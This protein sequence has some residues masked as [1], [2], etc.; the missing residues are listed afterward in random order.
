LIPPC[1]ISAALRPAYSNQYPVTNLTDIY[2]NCVLCPRHCRVDR[3]DR[4]E[5]AARGICG[6]SDRLRVAY[7]GPHFGEEPP[8]TGTNGSGTIFFSG[9]S[10]RCTYCQNHQI[11]HE[12]LGMAMGLDA[13][14]ERVTEVARRDRVHNIN[15]VTPDHFFPHVFALVSLLRTQG[16]DLPMVYNLSGYQ[17]AQSLVRAEAYADIYLPDY[18]YGDSALAATLSKCRDY[19]GVALDAITLMVRQK[20]FLDAVSSPSPLARRGVL[21]RHLILPGKVDNSIQALTG[22]FVEFGPGLPV[23]LM[24]QYHPVLQHKD[25][26]LNRRVTQAEFDAVLSHAEALGFEHLFVQFP[27]ATTCLDDDRSGF[28][29]DF[30]KTRPFIGGPYESCPSDG[31]RGPIDPQSDIKRLMP[32]A[33]PAQAG[34]SVGHKSL[35]PCRRSRPGV[36]P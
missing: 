25:P 11:S 35:T 26:D 27:E 33:D 10:L 7:V 6:E 16:I 14:A 12:G 4:R 15:F 29:P 13:L 20:G 24:S 1:G 34:N 3:T 5:N 22:L 8:I 30:E 31:A 23:S 36:Y 17:S 28:L 18:K 32:V 19:P 21:V 9:C 2:K